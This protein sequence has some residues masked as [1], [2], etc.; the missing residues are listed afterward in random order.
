MRTLRLVNRDAHTQQSHSPARKDP[1]NKNHR[2]VPRRTL[3]NCSYETNE[4]AD[5]NSEF[6]SKAIHGEPSHQRAKHSSAIERRVDGSYDGR[7]L[8]GIEI[9]EEV[10]GPDHVGHYTCIVAKQE[11]SLKSSV[12][13][14]CVWINERLTQWPRRS[15]GRY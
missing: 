1:S 13:Y 6:P 10:V 4:C 9:G 12:S 11:R 7:G 3:Q 14:R 15:R 5:L 8:H 2:Q